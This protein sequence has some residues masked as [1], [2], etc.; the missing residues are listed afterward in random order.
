MKQLMNFI[1]MTFVLT[2]LAFAS[3]VESLVLKPNQEV[4]LGELTGAGT[5]F[6]L[7]VLAGFVHPQ[8]YI[9]KDECSRIVV[10]STNSPKVSDVVAITVNGE[11][12]NAS[13][14]TG[15]IIQK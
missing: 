10:R 9:M 4:K 2:N 11:E 5:R 13:E 15:F 1:L 14:L 8:G 3:D 7:N 6:S 12:I